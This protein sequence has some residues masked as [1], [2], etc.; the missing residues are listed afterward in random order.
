M[1]GIA[2]NQMRV[3][4]AQYEDKK[5]N[6]YT[7][8]WFR[9]STCWCKEKSPCGERLVLGPLWGHSPLRQMPGAEQ[10]C[11]KPGARFM[12]R[13]CSTSGQARTANSG[14]KPPHSTG[15]A[16]LSGGM[17]NVT[18]SKFADAR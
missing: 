7:G 17:A 12:G 1:T 8:G 14:S 11:A 6:L 10:P 15:G 5:E 3:V 2:A 13:G 4:W 16:R 18:P 9:A